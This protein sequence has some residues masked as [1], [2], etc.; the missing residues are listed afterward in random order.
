MELIIMKLYERI[1]HRREELNMTQEELSNIL[2]YKS[3]STI[4]KIEKGENDI[5]Q[6]K[7]KAF[8][9]ALRTTTK[10]LMGDDAEQPPAPALALAITEQEQTHLDKYR[11]LTDE[12]K[13]AVDDFTEFQLDKQ[14]KELKQ[15][16]ISG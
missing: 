13:T 8:A 4:A 12:N 1:K 5:T 9:D 11:Q 6:T 10:Y 7:I 2:G 14:Q 16:S 3:R 15:E